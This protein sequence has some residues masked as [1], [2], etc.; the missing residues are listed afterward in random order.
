MGL[1]FNLTTSITLFI[2]IVQ[3]ESGEV[4]YTTA[5]DVSINESSEIEAIQSWSKLHCASLCAAD[6]SC[7]SA[8]YERD[9]KKCRLIASPTKHLISKSG[10]TALLGEQ[11]T[12]EMLYFIFIYLFESEA[13]V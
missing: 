13:L 11:N 7:V 10:T 2:E 8:N 4:R 12:G 5:H 3:A 9:N 1:G 6:A